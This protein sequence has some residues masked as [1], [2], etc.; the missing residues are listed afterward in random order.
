MQLFYTGRGFF[1]VAFID[2]IWRYQKHC[3]ASSYEW[4]IHIAFPRIINTR[5]VISICCATYKWKC[6][7]KWA[8]K[9]TCTWCQVFPHLVLF[10]QGVQVQDIPEL[11]PVVDAECRAGK[12]PVHGAD[13]FLQTLRRKS[14]RG[15]SF[16]SGFLVGVTW[17]LWMAA[18]RKS[19][20]PVL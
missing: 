5:S 18:I 17:N 8:C 16:Y 12:L 4:S 11:I 14:V 1:E 15:Q 7:W 2:F 10:V 3:G 19:S 13:G 9:D 20:E 6:R